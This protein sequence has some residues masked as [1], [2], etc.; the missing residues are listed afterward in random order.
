MRGA[1]FPDDAASLPGSGLGRI[2]IMRHH[3]PAASEAAARFDFFARSDAV[4]NDVAPEIVRLLHRST[5]CLVYG[6]PPRA[7]PAA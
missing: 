1:D 4:S 2:G 7:A 5:R 6:A 3:Q